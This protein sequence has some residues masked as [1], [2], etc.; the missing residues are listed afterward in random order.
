[1]KRH[2]KGFLAAG[3]AALAGALALVGVLGPASVTS[4][5]APASQANATAVKLAANDKPKP[6][7]HVSFRLVPSSAAIAKCLPHAEVEV[8]VKLRT[9]ATGRDIF[10]V[11]GSGL[12]A[13]TSF[14]I[15]LI[16][17]PGAPFG[18]AEYIGD[19]N[20][21]KR[22]RAH[23]ELRLIVEEAF[24]ST[25]V[26]GKRVRAEL[27]H[28]GMWFADPAADDFCLGPG[29]GAVTPFDG[30]NEA[31]VQAFNSANSL[32]GAPLP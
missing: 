18:A 11:E 28:V 7:D 5:S 1:V 6:K 27:N 2:T 10:L 8:T 24:A 22:G 26:D 14:T 4:A 13:N 29:G 23:A 20:T 9:E 17:V 31:G 30:D 25:I 12:P 19:L 32:P 15:F 16:E 3:A 21:D